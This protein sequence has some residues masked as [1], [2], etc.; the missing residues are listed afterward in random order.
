MMR[1]GAQVIFAGYPTE[2]IDIGDTGVVFQAG[3]TG[4]HVRWKTGARKGQIDLVANDDLT[5]NGTDRSVLDDSLEGG[6]TGRLE[7]R[8]VYERRGVVGVL[9]LMNE[10]GHLAAF[11]GYAEEALALIAAR[12]RHDPS[13]IE[14]SSSLEPHETDELVEFATAQLL[15]DAFGAS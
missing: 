2:G 8:S 13:F 1:D 14:V 7:V 6:L 5:V 15:R 9:N 12:I 11:D 4:S 10:E 3:T